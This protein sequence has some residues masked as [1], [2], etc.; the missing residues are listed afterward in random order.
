[1]P[2]LGFCVFTVIRV[3]AAYPRSKNSMVHADKNVDVQ[4]ESGH[5]N[6][7]QEGVFFPNAIFSHTFPTHI[8]AVDTWKTQVNPPRQISTYFEKFALQKLF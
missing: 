1:M 5:S 6:P 4:L 7:V 3:V 8:N 2:V